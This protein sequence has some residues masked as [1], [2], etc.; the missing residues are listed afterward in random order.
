MTEIRVRE[1]QSAG[2]CGSDFCARLHGE[3]G[4]SAV[5]CVGDTSVAT[6]RLCNNVLLRAISC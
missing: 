2:D 4:L 3:G 1:D 5:L 6:F